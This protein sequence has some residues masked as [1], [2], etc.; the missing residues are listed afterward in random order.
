MNSTPV[1]SGCKSA[2]QFSRVD[3]VLD[4]N[5]KR[6]TLDDALELIRCDQL[7]PS[8]AAIRDTYNSVLQ[9]TGSVTEAKK[10]V[11]DLK[12]ALPAFMFTGVFNGRGDT[13]LV[14]SSGLVVTDFD[15]LDAGAQ[16]A[17][18]IK[19][20]TDPCVVLVY[21]SPSS[22]I[23]AVYR[24]WAD[25][26]HSANFAALTL[27]IPL[28]FEDEMKELYLRNIA[29][30]LSAAVAPAKWRNDAYPSGIQQSP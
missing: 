28:T 3:N 20:I 5:P 1:N 2:I 26:P 11:K 29:S 30:I 24:A 12:A 27:L 18:R 4:K 19:L 13:S 7:R 10:A 22:G 9:A 25:Q 14:Q 23:K 21:A 17:L 8:V 16:A 15:H 6:C